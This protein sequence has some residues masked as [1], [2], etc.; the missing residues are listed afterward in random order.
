M[1]TIIISRELDYTWMRNIFPDRHPLLVPLCN[2]PFIEFL[3]DFS[4]LAGSSGIRIMS[5]D[6]ISDVENYC[7]KG[8][9]WGIDITYANMLPTDSTQK[10]LDKNSKF[11][12]D[13]RIMLI[14]SLLFVH[15]DRRRNYSSFFASIPA[16]EVHAC[17]NGN[18]SLTGI[19]S[20]SDNIEAAPP[21]SLTV[22]DSIGQYYALANEILHHRLTHYVLPG[23]NNEAECYIGRNVVIQKSANIIKPVIIGNN[24]Q[25]FAG[26]VIGPGAII[27]NNVIIDRESTVSE[28]I[29][30]DNTFIGEQL[31]VDRKIAAGNLLID[32]VSGYS[33]AMEDPHLLSGINQQ[34]PSGSFMKRLVHGLMACSLIIIL[35]LPYLL[36]K[37]LLDRL[38]FWKTD[39][40]II[41]SAKPGE[42]V[43]LTISSIRKKGLLGCI[44]I[45][46]SLDRFIWLFKV[47][48]GHLAIIG[49]RPVSLTR[50]ISGRQSSAARS[51]PG[52]F[53]YAE[54]EDWPK[55]EID[56]DIVDH[57]YA[58]HS[59]F[60][61]DI[62]MT[63]KALF[64][65]IH[66]EEK[67]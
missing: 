50:D 53:S 32:P 7:E 43:T 49:S 40:M 31:D 22:L 8:S 56:S 36:L 66:Q 33:L 19:A 30:M 25:I 17:S 3:I 26:S 21:L 39:K 13:E 65:R 64:N 9:R 16:G 18:L 28:S 48:S 51:I 15:Y 62:S 47:L 5:D 23:Y 24:V 42:K 35:L 27:G 52:V 29:V 20:P 1:K 60:I 11:C 6:V 46:L 55:N 37:P 57:Y 41:H 54:A 38:G 34:A 67:I 45:F 4:I 63:Q 58:V 44:A 14:N 61:K 2:K 12:S 59:N 10:I